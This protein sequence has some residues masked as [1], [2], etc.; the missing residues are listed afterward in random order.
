MWGQCN[1]SS[2]SNICEIAVGD[3][4]TVGITEA[5]YRAVACGNESTGACDVSSWRAING[6]AAGGSRTVALTD[7]GL[8]TT[9]GDA[10]KQCD[11]SNL[12]TM[13]FFP[14][15]GNVEEM[16]KKEREIAKKKADEKAERE[17]EAE[18]LR[19]EE[20]RRQEEERERK[21]DLRC[22]GLCQYCG[23]KF[24]GF[25]LKKCVQCGTKKDY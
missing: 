12:S 5:E 7:F 3:F 22:K 16:V 23:G 18:R 19:L 13:F 2:W 20:E 9:G 15:D 24:K 1:V 11:V 21:L 25:L 17:K 4:H 10:Y 6:I 14:T 8:V